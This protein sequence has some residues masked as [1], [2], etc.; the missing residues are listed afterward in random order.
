MLAA[1]QTIF[2]E[3]CDVFPGSYVHIGGDEVSFPAIDAI[4]EAQAEI[5]RL[6]LNSSY[7]LY[8]RFI[9]QMQDYAKGKGRELMVWE[10]FGPIQGQTGRAA[11]APSSVKIPTDGL[12]VSE[13]LLD[14]MPLFAPFVVR[15]ASG[16][17]GFGV[18]F[19]CSLN[20]AGWSSSGHLIVG[21]LRLDCVLIFLV[22]T[23]GSAV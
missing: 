16:L 21:R 13:F 5:K 6:G 10:G 15:L 11:K 14:G 2:D 18:A 20:W 17:R 19:W 7:D 9:T 23:L 8:R 3:I 22:P 4:P 1:L 12:V